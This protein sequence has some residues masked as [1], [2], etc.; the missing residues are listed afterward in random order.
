MHFFKDV[1]G[2]TADRIV[3]NS[4]H[5]KAFICILL[6]KSFIY[7]KNNKGDTLAP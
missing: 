4:H 5:R 1:I 3:D 7:N 6:G 2:R